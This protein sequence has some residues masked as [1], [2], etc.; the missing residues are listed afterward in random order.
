[1]IKAVP[2]VSLLL[3][4]IVLLLLGL[5]P[6]RSVLVPLHSVRGNPAC[7]DTAGNTQARELEP[8]TGTLYLCIGG[9]LLVH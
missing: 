8:E 4:A 9:F 3:L 6:L 7:Q 5:V 1:L 2:N